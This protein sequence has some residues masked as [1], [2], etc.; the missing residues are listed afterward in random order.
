MV[1]CGG[2]IHWHMRSVLS[3]ALEV[4]YSEFVE[5]ALFCNQSLL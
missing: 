5:K 1:Q 3:H 2:T 4:N